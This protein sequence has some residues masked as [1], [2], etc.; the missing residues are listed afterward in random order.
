MVDRFSIEMETIMFQYIWTKEL[1]QQK[2]RF[3]GIQNFRRSVIIQDLRNLFKQNP[4]SSSD[5]MR[6]MTK[7]FFI[8]CINS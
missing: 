6:K 4:S 8:T 5:D 1:A 2:L 3:K 7:T